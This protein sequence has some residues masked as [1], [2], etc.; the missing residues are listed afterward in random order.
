MGKTSPIME[1]VRIS[2]VFPG[3]AA[4]SDICLRVHAGEI[5]G[6]VGENGAG[7]STVLKILSGAI[8]PT[9]GQ[10]LI[11][12][13]SVLFRSPADSQNSGVASVYQNIHLASNLTVA[14]NLFLGRAAISS[15]F[16]VDRPSIIRQADETL[17]KL[18]FPEISPREIVAR[19][20][21]AQKQILSIV[22]AL[23]VHPKLLL[24]DEPTSSLSEAEVTRLFQLLRDVQQDGTAMI[25]VSHH[26]DEVF[27]IADNVA[28]LRDGE[29]A[30]YGD[31]S[32]YDF[33][34][35]KI[36][37]A[38]GGRHSDEQARTRDIPLSNKGCLPTTPPVLSVHSLSKKGCFED[39]SFDLFQGEVLGFSGL[40]GSGRTEL[41]KAI[42]GALPYDSGSVFV[43]G[44][45]VSIRSIKDAMK[46]GV[47]YLTED[48]LGEGIFP[49]MSVADNIVVGN[50]DVAVSGWTLHDSTRQSIAATYVSRLS[51]KTPSPRCKMAKLSGG[52]QQKCLLARLLNA[53]G[54]ILM[55]DEPTNGIDVSAKEEI[56]GIIRDFLDSTHGAVIMISSDLPEVLAKSDRIAVMREGKLAGI[57]PAREMDK[58]SVLHHMLQV[59]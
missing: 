8:Q 46:L 4:L 34:R 9:R 54:R 37:M 45:K 57:F 12:G 30:S 27:E 35:V 39:V 23:M 31:A 15:G 10:I 53:N 29:L 32:E 28:I 7:K 56:H 38:G 22:K 33:E 11:D 58:S 48:R 16:V 43:D 1:L 19:L 21:H 41:A 42:F 17:E 2:K 47:L 25:F 18:G 55:L 59:S 51:I 49:Q 44:N 24:L 36:I 13:N 52:N 14:E 20:S 6:L 50:P 3:V 5:L 26:L 40:V